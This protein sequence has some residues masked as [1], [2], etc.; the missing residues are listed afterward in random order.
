MPLHYVVVFF[1]TTTTMAN[2]A[3]NGNNWQDALR[4]YIKQNPTDSWNRI[5]AL[6]S[7]EFPRW[8]KGYEKN[9]GSKSFMYQFLERKAI[10]SGNP[11]QFILQRF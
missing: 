2:I 1:N 10:A 7:N 5:K 3:I 6:Y 4:N 8:V 11:V 9:D